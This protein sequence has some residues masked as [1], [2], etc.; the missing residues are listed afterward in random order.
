[1]FLDRLALRDAA[2]VLLSLALASL[3][4]FAELRVGR[5]AVSITPPIGVPIGSSYGLTPA[6]TVHDDCLRRRSCSKWTAKRQRWWHA[7]W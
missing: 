6:A 3:P 5:A 1:V 7:I 2:C 4:A